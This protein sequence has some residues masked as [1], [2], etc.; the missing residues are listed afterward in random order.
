ML[1]NHSPNIISSSEFFPSRDMKVDIAIFS[2][3]AEEL[4]FYRTH[5]L[6]RNIQPSTVKIETFDFEIYHYSGKKILL[7][8]TGLGTTFA[9]SV[10][11]MV[12]NTCHPDYVFLSGTAGGI[13]S[14]LKLRDVVI[15]ENAFEAE[16]QGIFAAIKNT[17]FESCLIHPLSQ[18]EFPS[19]YPASKELLDLAKNI[20]IPQ[21]CI[22]TAVSSNT[23]P[24]P[25][26]LFDHIKELNAYSIDMETS[27]FYQVAWLLKLRVLAVRG[28]SNVLNLDGTD[29]KVH[30]SDV[31]GS[32]NA[33]ATVVMTIVDQ[34]ILKLSYTLKQPTNTDLMV[35]SLIKNLSLLPHPEGGFYKRIY[36]SSINVKP[37]N[38]EYNG[39]I[40]HAGTA[41]YYLLKENDFSAWHAINSDELWHFYKGSP[42]KI[43][44]L[45]KDGNLQIHLLGDPIVEDGAKFQITVSANNWFAAEIVDKIS[46]SLVG[47]TVNPGFDFKYFRLGS[48]KV[49]LNLFPKHAKLINQFTRIEDNAIDQVA[50]V[51]AL[52]RSS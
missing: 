44:E 14:D 3:M 18:N 8:K 26:E 23:F 16:I 17:P 43:Y 4:E 22:G 35:D 11:T 45:N 10:L 36:E 46:Y 37:T 30:E 48:R 1:S 39:K 7:G 34:L 21:A 20:E 27:A 38:E 9:A 6:E 52:K 13:K 25:K 49:L 33:A 42:V 12:N 29:D 40:R 51:P 31:P 47:C 19:S 28:I 24:S 2:A 41:I 50:F 15:V 5:F 32:A